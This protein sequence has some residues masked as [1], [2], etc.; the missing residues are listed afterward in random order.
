MLEAKRVDVSPFDWTCFSDDGNTWTASVARDRL[1]PPGLG[2]P[3][4]TPSPPGF[5]GAFMVFV[6]FWSLVPL[7]I[8]V[9]LAHNRGESAG[10]AVL[11]TLVLAGTDWPSC[12]SGRAELA[13][14]WRDW[15]RELL[16]HSRHRRQRRRIRNLHQVLIC[17]SKTACGAWS[18]SAVSDS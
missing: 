2:G 18:A 11:L 10:V 5:F 6:L 15:P 12:T 13:T 16:R 7:L 9:G 14:P 17:R 3:A 8:A 4:E 1:A